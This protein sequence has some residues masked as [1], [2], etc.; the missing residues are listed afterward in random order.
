MLY[1]QL[2]LAAQGLDDTDSIIKYAL[3]ILEA[4]KTRQEVLS[5]LIAMLLGQGTS[6]EELLTLL[7]KVYTINDPNELLTIARAA[8]D[9]G[10]VEFARMIMI[11]AGEMLNA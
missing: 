10:A 6:P 1:T 11:I 7:T 8:K 2:L 3:L 9:C 5:P 4:D